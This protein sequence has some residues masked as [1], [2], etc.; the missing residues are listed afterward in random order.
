MENCLKIQILAS[1]D[2][3]VTGACKYLKFLRIKH[4]FYTI[5]YVLKSLRKHFC[6][7]KYLVSL[8]KI[9]KQKKEVIQY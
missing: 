8:K 1:Q 3:S 4:I 6:G 7:S 9:A 2:E 5:F